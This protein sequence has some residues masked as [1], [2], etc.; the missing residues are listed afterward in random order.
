MAISEATV[1]AGTKIAAN[2]FNNVF[3]AMAETNKKREEYINSISNELDKKIVD[4]IHFIETQ[5]NFV[6][7]RVKIAKTDEEVSKLIGEYNDYCNEIKALFDERIN[8]SEKELERKNVTEKRE[9][10]QFRKKATLAVFTGGVSLLFD[11]L[12]KDKEDNTK[13]ITKK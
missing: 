7:E 5:I 3:T 1:V 2:T 6:M 10:T 13:K 9:K 4:K 8:N 11:A 12:K